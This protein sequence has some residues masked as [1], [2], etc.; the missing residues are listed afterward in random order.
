MFLQYINFSTHL[1]DSN[2]SV[3]ILSLPQLQNRVLSSIRCSPTIALP[4]QHTQ[5]QIAKI[6][7]SKNRM[8]TIGNNTNADCQLMTDA[9]SIFALSEV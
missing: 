7:G 3:K 1:F 8:A 4:P 6:E 9:S 2:T 5:C